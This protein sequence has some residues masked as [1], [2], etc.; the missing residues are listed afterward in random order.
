MIPATFL[1]RG[2]KPRDVAGQSARLAQQFV[3]LNRPY[4]SAVGT[5]IETKFD[6]QRVDLAIETNTTVGAVPLVSPTTGKHDYGLVVRP[7]FE[8]K[9]LGP[10]LGEM[11]WRTVPSVLPMPLLPRSERKV[12]PWVLSSMLLLRLEQMLSH[13]HRKFQMVTAIRSAPRGHVDW[14]SYATRSV[15]RGEYLRVPCHFPD[16]RVDTEL[17]AGI[18]FCLRKVRAS[19]ESQRTAG[20]FILQLLELCARLTDKVDSVPPRQ[21]LPRDLLIWARS[22]AID[23]GALRSGLQAME[24]ITDDRG[25]AG[26]ADL[27]GLPW[28][29]PMESF[30]E[31]WCEAVMADV[32]R[33]IGGTLKVGRRRQTIAPLEWTP[34]YLGSQR[35][36]VPDITLERGNH[37]VIVDAK[38]KRHWE[39]LQRSGWRNL[40]EELRESHRT[41]LLQVLAYANLSRSERTLV[42][43]AYPCR[44]DTWNSLRERGLMFHRASLNAG[45]RSIDIL[46]TALPMG[47]RI[48]TVASALAPQL[49]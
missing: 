40:E 25:L 10:M 48:D 1:L 26:L 49:I 33:K 12:P 37:T 4:L 39:E 23:A 34:S 36:L 30:F 20:V 2:Q 27:Q 43:L 18:H 11:G 22:T 14:A 15:A 19:L 6:G 7:R 32:S 46:L 44:K 47:E 42:C 17:Q 21:P 31:A 45:T 24:W 29:M 16:L 41:D 28:H 8:W 38:Y 13:M 9:G 5:S 35:Y 3:R